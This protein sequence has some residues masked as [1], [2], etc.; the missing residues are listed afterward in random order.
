MKTICANVAADNEL[1]V[2]E[3]HEELIKE[4]LDIYAEYESLGTLL[5]QL[6][7]EIRTLASV[8][9]DTKTK[10]F[11]VDRNGKECRVDV[12]YSSKR[13]SFTPKDEARLASELG[14]ETVDEY[15]ISVPQLT[16]KLDKIDELVNLV[17]STGSDVRKFF[18]SKR[19]IQAVPGELPPNVAK[20]V[21]YEPAVKVRMS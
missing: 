3:G 19:V 13:K 17:K 1:Q 8:D 18:T 6:K 21:N 15:F 4:Y 20:Y 10:S 9:A 7:R 2:V 14:R 16:P 5:D 12:T 11:L